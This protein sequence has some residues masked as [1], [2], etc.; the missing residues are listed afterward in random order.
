[1]Q[2]IQLENQRKKW[3]RSR[4]SRN[5]RTEQNAFASAWDCLKV[6]S[7]NYPLTD[8]QFKSFLERP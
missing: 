8:E 1:M 3:Y 2:L 5:A 4:N 6:C 7:R